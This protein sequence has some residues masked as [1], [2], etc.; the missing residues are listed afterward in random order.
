MEAEYFGHTHLEDTMAE[1]DIDSDEATV[2]ITKAVTKYAKSGRGVYKKQEVVYYFKS[3]FVTVSQQKVQ[4]NTGEYVS[5]LKYFHKN[6]G[7]LPGIY[8]LGI[9][10]DEKL[11]MGF[12][13]NQECKTIETLMNFQNILQKCVHYLDFELMW[14]GEGVVNM[15]V[16]CKVM[17]RSVCKKANKK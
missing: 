11:L 15:E 16:V 3:P 1:M 12:F 13:A 17:G 4:T 5:F 14:E 7:I 10:I 9:D 8:S 2:S 6:K